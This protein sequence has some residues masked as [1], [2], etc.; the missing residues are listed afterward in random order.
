MGNRTAG[1]KVGVELY[2]RRQETR[3]EVL[4]AL[5]MNTVALRGI[6]PCSLV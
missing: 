3:L 6:A 1:R 4:T 5:N 2:M